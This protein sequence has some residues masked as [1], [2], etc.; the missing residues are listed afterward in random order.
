MSPCK[1]IRTG[2]VTN[3]PGEYDPNRPH[4]SVTCCNRGVCRDK[5]KRWVA[6][7]TNETAYFIPDYDR[8]LQL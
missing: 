1:H 7:Q 6:G 3:Q 2:I 4:A 8:S 5:A